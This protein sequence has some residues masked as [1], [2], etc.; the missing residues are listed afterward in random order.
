M[1]WLAIGA[2]HHCLPIKDGFIVLSAIGE[3]WEPR[4]LM[5]DGTA[6]AIGPQLTLEYALGFAEDYVRQLGDSILSNADASW[7]DDRTTEKQRKLLA[8]MGHKVSPTMT[9]G[10]ASDLISIAKA[11][12]LLHQASAREVPYD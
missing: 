8:F 1:R 12:M 10:Q 7:L 3:K 4:Q 5:A 6:T 2:A 11:S 9:R